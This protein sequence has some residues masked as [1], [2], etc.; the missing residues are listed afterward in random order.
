MAW[1]ITASSSVGVAS[2]T[3]ETGYAERAPSSIHHIHPNFMR[4]Y[5]D[6]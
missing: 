2:A 3:H 5:R 4:R 6:A 1:H